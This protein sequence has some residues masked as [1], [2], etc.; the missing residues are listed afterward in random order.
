MN[1]CGDGIVFYLD[2]SGGHTNLY[3]CKILW[4]YTDTLTRTHIWVHIKLGKSEQGW[5]ILSLL[6]CWLWYCTIGRQDITIGGNW[7]KSTLSLTSY[8]CRRSYSYFKNRKFN[9]KN[10]INHLLYF[11][12][13]PPICRLY[14]IFEFSG[15]IQFSQKT[16]LPIL[17]QIF[18]QLHN[19]LH[20]QSILNN[21]WLRNMTFYHFFWRTLFKNT[22]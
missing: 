1:P 10:H 3:I 15:Y 9:L 11:W 13:L 14:I 4:N 8:N 7:I 5:R 18:E 16:Q 2:C 6:I 20:D 19:N 17:K 12:G 21:L 22:W